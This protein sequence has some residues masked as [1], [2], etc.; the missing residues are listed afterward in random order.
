MADVWPSAP[1]TRE[2]RPPRWSEQEVEDGGYVGWAL[3]CS[4][5][6]LGFTLFTTVYSLKK[7]ELP[8]FYLFLIA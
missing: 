1:W 8:P 6:Y 3:H 2:Q 4:T 7:I 5:Q